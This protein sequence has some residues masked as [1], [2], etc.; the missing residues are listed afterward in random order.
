MAL[1]CPVDL[2]TRRL[3][4]EVS[5][6]YARVATDPNGNYHFHRGPQ[7]A[8]TFLG[9][10]PHE[11]AMLPR[12]TTEPFAGV[13][14]PHRVAPLRAGETVLDVGCGAGTDLLL[15]AMHVGPHGKAIGVDMT[16]VMLERAR[17]SAAARGLDH[18]EVRFGEAEGLPADDAS[19]DVV[20]SNGVI[21]LT[22]DKSRAFSEIRRVLR[23]GGRL[24]L[25]DIIVRDELSEAIRRDID[26]WTG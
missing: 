6:L 23:P 4:Q 24:M 18:V 15:A 12:E 21:N 3:K 17:A 8:V 26:L 2:D 19:V 5:S 22:P 11:L 16:D 10:D 9:Y 7:Y 20:I 13:G 1:T 25:A 14:N